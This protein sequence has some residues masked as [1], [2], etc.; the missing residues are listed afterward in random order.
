MKNFFLSFNTSWKHF[1]LTNLLSKFWESRFSS[2]RTTRSR[3]S[4]AFRT[5]KSRTFI[6]L[7]CLSLCLS[8]SISACNANNSTAPPKTSTSASAKTLR[9]GYQNSGVFFLVKNRGGLEKRLAPM[10]VKVEWSEFSSP[11]PLIEALGAKSIDIGQ[12]SD[13]GM[14]TAQAAGIDLLT[15]ANSR[16]SPKS[17]AIVV[18][19]DSPVQKIEDLKGKKI[20]FNKGSAAQYLVTQAIEKSGLSYSDIKPVFLLP[21]EAR[22]AFEQGSIDA[23]AIWDPYLAAAEKESQARVLVNGEGLVTFRE[24]YIASRS[25]TQENPELVKQIIT[26]AQV[27]GDWAIAN[28]Q[29]VA[30]LLAPELKLDV[31]TLELAESRKTRYGAKLIQSEAVAETQQ[32]ANKF[33]QLKLIPKEI[34]IKNTVW[35]NQQQAASTKE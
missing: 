13:A 21:P 4:L 11:T 17:L 18:P 16:P 27:V 10:N 32:V 24:F 8:L 20:A 26:E 3:L 30:Q 5:P 25:F 23:W 35:S 29:K 7:F 2:P 22:A 28:P 31:S 12:T 9:I 15:V 6:W 1:N 33:Y 34:Q 19:S 14:V